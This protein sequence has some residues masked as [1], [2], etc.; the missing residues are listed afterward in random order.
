MPRLILIS[1]ATILSLYYAARTISLAHG[2]LTGVVTV[3]LDNEG[4]LLCA[5]AQ[6]RWVVLCA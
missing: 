5:F 2:K 1:L 4:V 3:R 6:L